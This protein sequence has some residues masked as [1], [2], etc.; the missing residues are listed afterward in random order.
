LWLE[1]HQE[2]RFEVIVVPDDISGSSG[3]GG[4]PAAEIRLDGY[5]PKD[6]GEAFEG[7]PPSSRMMPMGGAII[8]LRPTRHVELKM[9]EDTQRSRQSVLALSG[10]IDPPME[11]EVLWIDLI[12]PEDRLRIADAR[13]DSQG[14]FKAEFD[15]LIEPTLY[16]NEEHR[17]C[18][19]IHGIYKA[20]AR[21]LESGRA[22]ECE[23]DVV[24]ITR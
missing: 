12:D 18:N 8:K 16:Y 4:L 15:I 13:T 7:H 19:L 10:S 3:A 6:Y 5:L 2:R 9:S 24:C 22:S 14:R 21:I 20:Q 11:G 17:P 1:P 23:S